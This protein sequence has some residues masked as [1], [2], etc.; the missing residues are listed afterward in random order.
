MIP[1]TDTSIKSS[2]KYKRILFVNR[3][4]VL[5]FA[6]TGSYALVNWLL[7]FQ[8]STYIYIIFM[9]YALCIYILNR[10]GKSQLMKVI[11]LLMFNLIIFIV[12]SSELFETGMNLYFFAAGTVALTIYDFN[13]WPKALFFASLS[14]VLYLLVYLDYFSVLPER[15]FS[16]SQVKLYFIINTVVNASVCIY[17]FLMFS[18][19]N[20]VAE[21]NLLENEQFMLKQNEKLTKANL[22]LD[23]FVYSVSH[24]LR[25]PLSSISGLIH[26]AEKSPDP[27]ETNQYLNLMKG[28]IV[29]LDQFIRDIIDGP[30]ETVI[31]KLKEKLLV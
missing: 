19:L 18:K 23:K 8:T 9:F 11:G 20:F 6:V 26:L 15:S 7:E 22:E 5:V 12:A 1:L 4:S 2:I 25:A 17:S 10:I 16:E 29:R 30:H 21:K 31:D 3:L 24:D 28:R 27:K 14:S 13:D